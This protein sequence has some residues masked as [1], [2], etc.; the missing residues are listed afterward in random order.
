MVQCEVTAA[1]NQMTGLQHALAAA[2]GI[3]GM[4]LVVTV[5]RYNAE[6]VG[7]VFQEIA[8]SILQCGTLA[9]VDLV[10]QQVDNIGMSGSFFLEIVQVFLLA[11]VVY[12][13]NVGKA[14]LQKTVDDRVEL[15]I[16]IQ[17]GE[18][19]RDFGKIVHMVTP[20]LTKRCDRLMTCT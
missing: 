12:K 6:T 15:L 14:I 10:V 1:Q 20:F 8:E 18:Y 19:D 3:L 4:V 5:H 17:R 13:N 11:A 7:T 16:G 9:L 2:S